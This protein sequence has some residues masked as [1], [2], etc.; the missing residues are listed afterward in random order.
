[1]LEI[2]VFGGLGNQMFQY[3][4]YCYLKEKNSDVILNTYDFSVI[5]HH[6]GFELNRIFGIE[7]PFNNKK[8]KWAADTYCFVA[9]VISKIGGIQLKKATEYVEHKEVSFIP[10]IKINSDLFLNGYWQDSRYA[11]AVQEELRK[12]FLFPRLQGKKNIDLC[13]SIKKR[14]SVAIHVRRGDYLGNTGFEGICDEKY[15][16]KAINYF[17]S[18]INNPLFVVFSDDIEWCKK[19]FADKEMI[20]VDWN[21]DDKSYI[22]MQLMTLCKHNIIANSTFSWWGAFL[23]SNLDKIVICPRIWNKKYNINHLMINGWH[24][25]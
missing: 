23:N 1:M 17:E 10:Q 6:Q 22:D 11:L 7:G 24:S 4:L 21:I 20:Y 8:S 9:R 25:I 16:L 13:N 19:K 15:Y 5:E 3:A 2:K 12:S 14:E 18:Y